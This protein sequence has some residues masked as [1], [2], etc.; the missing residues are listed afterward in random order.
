M[1]TTLSELLNASLRVAG[2]IMRPNW[3]L[4]VDMAAELIPALNRMLGSWNIDGSKIFTTK[5]ETFPLTSGVKTYTIG[6]GGDFD[7]ARPSFYQFANI[8]YPTGPVVRQP[9]QILRN[10]DQWAAIRVQDIPGAPAWVIY[11]DMANPLTTLYLYPQPPAGYTLELYT[12]QALS[13]YTAISDTVV[14]PDGYEEAIVWNLGVRAAAM[15]PHQAKLDPEAKDQAR[16]S[17]RAVKT[18]NAKTPPL[19]TDPAL[20]GWGGGGAG[21]GSG[22]SGGWN[23]AAPWLDGGIF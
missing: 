9:M 19:C 1:S 3:T 17:L 11:P 13:K 21:G 16:R 2:I 22:E 5:I 12:W 23:D 4:S 20:T 14:V 15:Y 7:T 18:L 8:L 10:V 6:P